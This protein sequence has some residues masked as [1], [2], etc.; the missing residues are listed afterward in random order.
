MMNVWG[1]FYLGE[2]VHLGNLEFIADYF[3]SL[4]ISPRRGDSG[5][6]FMGSTHS[7]ASSAQWPMIE[8]SAKEFL[9]TSS[10]DGGFGLPSPTRH[11]TGAPSTPVITTPWLKD[12]IDITIA[13]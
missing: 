8:D 6:T 9:T 13:Q 10:R 5:T 11:G 7:G 12:I 2:T 4:N 3:G 1:G